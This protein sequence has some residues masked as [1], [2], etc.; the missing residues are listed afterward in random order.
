MITKEQVLT[1]L[2]PALE[3]REAFLIDCSIDAANKI[4]VVADS[5]QG[6]NLE[7]ITA[8]SRAIEHQLDRDIEDFELT[9]TSPGVGAPLKVAEQYQQNVGRVLKLQTK[10]GE[11]MEGELTSFEDDTLTLEWRTRVPK[12]IGKG[13][14]TVIKKHILPRAEIA[15]AKVQVRFK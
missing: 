15:E 10:Q 5:L 6:V 12:E 4:V 8:L 11:K 13:K 3:E 2:K 14:Q 7:D 1:L 9:V